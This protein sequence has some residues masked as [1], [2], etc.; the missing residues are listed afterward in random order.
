MIECH[1]AGRDEGSAEHEPDQT[2]EVLALKGHPPAGK[3]LLLARTS[4]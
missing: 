1:Y 2:A 3:A 4:Q